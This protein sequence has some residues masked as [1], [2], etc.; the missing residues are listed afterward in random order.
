MDHLSFSSLNLFSR[1]PEQFHRIKLAGL[2]EDAPQSTQEQ[3]RGKIM[4]K[5]MEEI[6]KRKIDMGEYP[7]ESDAE[8]IL[9]YLW[10]EGWEE[11]GKNVLDIE[12]ETEFLTKTVD[13][14]YTLIPKI[15]KRVLPDLLPLH[16]EQE[17]V[18]DL[19]HPGETIK[20]LVGTVD[21]VADG[22][23]ITD[24]KTHRSPMNDKWID[25]ELQ[26]T[27]YTALIG[28]P[29]AT[30]NFVQFIF[31]S[32][33]NGQLVVSSTKR[34]VRHVD[35]LLNVHIP[36]VIKAIETENF[37]ASPGWVCYFCPVKCGV[38]PS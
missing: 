28:L 27:V 34:D 5:L 3:V 35:W 16:T 8:S 1:C 19:P 17:I 18:I 30:I 25:V 36:S 32:A 38:F 37:V 29:K 24:W 31:G 7:S 10:E 20:Q 33:K 22:G 9:A 4:H 15:Y 21:L 2:P 11:K 13:Q 26:A 12:W 23:I 6:I 14:S